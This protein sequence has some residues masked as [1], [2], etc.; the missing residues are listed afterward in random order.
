M[1]KFRNLTVT[2]DDPV[3]TWGVE[4][5]LTAIERGGG[6]DWSRVACAAIAAGPDS[7]LWVDLAQAL[8]VSD[9]GGRTLIALMLKQSQATPEERV[10]A[11]IRKAF[12]MAN[13]SITDFA[14][15]CG[16]SRSR[17]STYLSGKTEPMSSMLEKMEMVGSS[18][19]DE[20]MFYR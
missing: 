19:R 13:M 4:G 7:V 16:T 2:P 10:R 1:M 3:D 9:G 12:N 11:R 8:E 5:L 20:I 18:R 14:E 17:M 15:R 6:R